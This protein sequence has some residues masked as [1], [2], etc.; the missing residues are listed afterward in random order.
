MLQEE[1]KEEDLYSISQIIELYPILSKHLITNAINSGD[2]EV[3][4]IGNKR[5]FKLNDIDNYLKKQQ[6]KI[7]NHIP[8][9]IESW[10][11]KS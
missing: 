6:E 3:T 8:K 4:W 7:D 10:R 2:L 5:Y 1:K 11:N 9:V